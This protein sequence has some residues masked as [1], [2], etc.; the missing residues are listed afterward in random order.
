MI[1]IFGNQLLFLIGLSYTN[2]TYAAA[3]QPAIP[4]FTF[5]L[6]VMMGSVSFH[7]YH[8]SVSI[9]VCVYYYSNTT[10]HSHFEFINIYINKLMQIHQVIQLCLSVETFSCST[11]R[12]N[13]ARYDGL[14]KVGGTI[15]C[16]SGAV[17]MVLYRGPALIGY[18]EIDHVIQNEISA[19]GQPEPSGWLIGSLLDFGLDHF[20]LGVLCL[21]G[22]CICMAAFLAIQVLSFWSYALVTVEYIISCY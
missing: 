18:A 11:E 9:C 6:A 22:N 4:V 16:V 14:A 1:R 20:H 13:L 17:L 7:L 10:A 5:M 15:I 3:I 19:K 12:V 21:I 8:L 2:P